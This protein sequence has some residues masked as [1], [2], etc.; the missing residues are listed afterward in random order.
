MRSSLAC[1]AVKSSFDVV[2]GKR[3][4]FVSIGIC[5]GLGLG[6]QFADLTRKRD[7]E[8]APHIRG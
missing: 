5:L 2:N 6:A 8:N 4:R 7:A 1:L 3:E